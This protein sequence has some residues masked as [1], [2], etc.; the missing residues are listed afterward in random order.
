MWYAEARMED[1]KEATLEKH[2][3]MTQMTARQGSRVLTVH[4]VSMS[5]TGVKIFG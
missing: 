1:E 2:R 3:I 4:S 5:E